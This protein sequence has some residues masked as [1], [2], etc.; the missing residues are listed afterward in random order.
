MPRV[1]FYT[2]KYATLEEGIREDILSRC[3][4]EVGSRWWHERY[5]SSLHRFTSGNLTR[6]SIEELRSEIFHTLAP[7][8]DKYTVHRVEV[9]VKNLQ[10]E[11][12]VSVNPI[13]REGQPIEV[14]FTLGGV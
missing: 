11:I 7:A 6:S 1:S 10:V 14:A 5:G 4:T 12:N 3:L 8:R 9:N 2:G 13:P